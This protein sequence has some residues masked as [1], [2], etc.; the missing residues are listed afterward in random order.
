MSK[1]QKRRN[2][3]RSLLHE[4]LDP[5]L[6]MTVESLIQ[7]QVQ[8]E[9]V[10]Q[11]SSQAL[12]TLQAAQQIAGLTPG[13]VVSPL[14]VTTNSTTP[15]FTQPT[16]N[17]T[18]PTTVNTTAPQT[19]GYSSTSTSSYD[20]S[21]TTSNP[22]GSGS[23][24]EGSPSYSLL[25]SNSNASAV[26]YGTSSYST[27]YGSDYG[28]S[29]GSD[30]G[31]SSSGG[32]SSSNSYPSSTQDYYAQSNSQYDYWSG[33]SG[34][35]SYG[36]T[37]GNYGDNTGSTNPYGSGYGEPDYSGT[38][39]YGNGG[40]DNGNN[41][42]PDDQNST[43]SSASTNEQS[44]DWLSFDEYGR[45][46][47]TTSN[48][49]ELGPDT[50]WSAS[51][52]SAFSSLSNYDTTTQSEV[53][54][55]EST[56]LI[57]DHRTR[58]YE[59]LGNGNYRYIESGS[60]T[61]DDDS[62]EGETN[63]VSFT[64][65]I[66]KFGDLTT[67]AILASS[68]LESPP[69]DPREDY[70]E[71]M[72]FQYVL[73]F[74]GQ[75]SRIDNLI[76]GTYSWN[77]SFDS[78]EVL[79]EEDTDELTAQG[80]A[81]YVFETSVSLLFTA[82]VVS[83]T[84]STLS[85]A[86]YNRVGTY[87]V[88]L[89]EPVDDYQAG[90]SNSSNYNGDDQPDTPITGTLSG[91][92]SES[93]FS[94]I[95][96]NDSFS[97]TIDVGLTAANLETTIT[98]NFTF[99]SSG[100]GTYG[101][102][103]I[104]GTIDE[105]LQES[106]SVNI[107][108]N[109][110]FADGAWDVSGEFES[111]YDTISSYSDSWSGTYEYELELGTMAGEISGSTS[112]NYAYSIHQI[113]I[114]MWEVAEENGPEFEAI[115]APPA[116]GESPAQEDEE[117]QY[118]WLISSLSLSESSSY[119]DTSEYSGTASL[120]S[121]TMLGISTESGTFLTSNNYQLELSIDGDI[122]VG[123]GNHD[124]VYSNE[125]QFNQTL[126]G[127]KT[128]NQ[129]VGTQ[130]DNFSITGK[131]YFASS[132]I[133]VIEDQPADA[134]SS[135]DAEGSGWRSLGGNFDNRFLYQSD[136]GYSVSGTVVSGELSGPG[137]EKEQSILYVRS[138]FIGS[139]D[140]DENL[141]IEDATDIESSVT[142]FETSTDLQGSFSEQAPV[143]DV[144]ITGTETQAK[145]TSEITRF[146]R[147]TDSS[148][149]SQPPI[150]DGYYI[151]SLLE[152]S[153]SKKEAGGIYQ[154]E[155]DDTNYSGTFSYLLEGESEST[156]SINYVYDAETGWT[157]GFTDLSKVPAGIN[158]AMIDV[159]SMDT[160]DAPHAAMNKVTFEHGFHFAFL[161]SGVIE[162]DEDD[163]MQLT[164][165]A[166]ESGS[167]QAVVSGS[168]LS[169]AN[170]TTTGDDDPLPEEGDA[171][172]LAPDSATPDQPAANS[173]SEDED[174]FPELVWTTTGEMTDS[175]AAVFRF[176][177]DASGTFTSGE[178]NGSIASEMEAD[179]SSGSLERFDWDQTTDDWDQVFGNRFELSDIDSGFRSSGEGSID[180]GNLSGSITFGSYGRLESN[181]QRIDNYVVGTEEWVS[182]GTRS[183]KNISRSA[184][185]VTLSGLEEMSSGP[186]T[187]D[188]EVTISVKS[189]SRTASFKE[190][191][192][193][194]DPNAS[195]SSSSAV[196][197]YRWSQ[198]DGA[199]TTADD[200][201]TF[202]TAVGSGPYS[203]ETANSLVSGDGY[204]NQRVES[205]NTNYT[206]RIF[207]VAANDWA[208]TRKTITDYDV[209][210]DQ[211]YDGVGGYSY[212]VGGGNVT[213]T[214]TESDSTHIDIHYRDVTSHRKFPSESQEID[215][216]PIEIPPH[217]VDVVAASEDFLQSVPGL[218]SSF[219][220]ARALTPNDGEMSLAIE[221]SNSLEI[222]GTGSFVGDFGGEGS[223]TIGEHSLTG[224]EASFSF[225]TSKDSSG[226]W[227]ELEGSQTIAT[228]SIVEN[229]QSFSGDWQRQDAIY[230]LDGSL[231][232]TTSNKN[233]NTT[234]VHRDLI[235]GQ[236]QGSRTVFYEIEESRQDFFEGDGPYQHET[237][238]MDISGIATNGK[239]VLWTNNQTLTRQY[240]DSGALMYAIGSGVSRWS[241]SED[242][243]RNGG[244]LY[245]ANSGDSNTPNFSHASVS[246]SE[247]ET[248]S[249]QNI[250]QTT[251][252]LADGNL[253]PAYKEYWTIGN[254]RYFSDATAEASSS[255]NIST[256]TSSYSES[257]TSS[258]SHVIESTRVQNDY[259]LTP[260]ASGFSAIVI[261]GGNT[262][263]S[264]TRSSS[265]QRSVDSHGFE[266]NSG[267][268]WDAVYIKERFHFTSSDT[269]QSGENVQADGTRV[270]FASGH[271]NADGENSWERFVN[272][273]KKNGVEVDLPEFRP[274]FYNYDT[275]AQKASNS[276]AN[277][278]YTPS[279][280]RASVGD[281]KGLVPIES[282]EHM[283]ETVLPAGESD[284]NASPITYIWSQNYLNQQQ[285]ELFDEALSQFAN[286]LDSA[287]DDEATGSLQELLKRTPYKPSEG[288][289]QLQPIGPY[290]PGD[291]HM[292]YLAEK[293][294]ASVENYIP[295]VHSGATTYI[296]ETTGAKIWLLPTANGWKILVEEG[297][298]EEE[299]QRLLDREDVQRK[300]NTVAPPY[301]M[302]DQM[303][304]ID[305][306]FYGGDFT[307]GQA[308]QYGG[309]V[310]GFYKGYFING[311]KA[312]LV[313]FLEMS[314]NP[315]E[316]MELVYQLA[317]MVGAEGPLP[318]FQAIW[319]DV[320][321]SASGD[322][323]K[324]GE[325]FFEVVTA[326]LG[327]AATPSY[328]QKF[329]R[330]K[331]I[332]DK[333]GK[334]HPLV[335]SI[336][337]MG[338]KAAEVVSKLRKMCFARDTLVS[339]EHGLR[340]IGEVLSGEKVYA[341]DFSTGE[342]TLRAVV[343]RI[344]S[345]YSGPMVHIDL[346]PE[347][348]A[349][350]MNHPLW[351]V[352]GIG[353]R[354][355]RT[356]AGF[357]D[358]QDQGGLLSGRWVNSQDLMVGDLLF[359]QDGQLVPIERISQSLVSGF[360]VSNLEVAD[361]HT[362]A[363]GS[364]RV[365]AHNEAICPTG[366]AFLRDL[367]VSGENSYE[368]IK[369]FV[370]SFNFT[371]GDEVLDKLK[372][373]VPKGERV[374]QH[375]DEA[376]DVNYIGITDDLK[377]RAGQHRLDKAKS[378]QSMKPMTDVL[379]HDQASTIEAMKIRQRLAEARAKGLIDGTEPVAEQLRKAGL[380]N[381]NR[382]RDP[383]RWIDID[384][385]D[386][387]KDFDD[388]FDIR[389]PNG[390]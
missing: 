165:T 386:F 358:G 86:Y 345:M 18:S 151:V 172:T 244:A 269:A 322:S 82:N 22:Y 119:L 335:K 272:G 378:G 8:N 178:I 195:T 199:E 259:R 354:D 212:E 109:V 131:S 52:A 233:T 56:L 161:G 376:G 341:F 181:S 47:I 380:L 17:S 258:S 249:N 145:L 240:D 290:I 303:A 237:G 132:S 264:D 160:V 250:E 373:L 100:Q 72:A 389:T 149:L 93:G 308:Q 282:I 14:S 121:G 166:S 381:N 53:D 50:V 188:A 163:S 104:T 136:A 134:P 324:Q 60:R 304:D 289:L 268:G 310:V 103:R 38:D 176:T 363:V 65:L 227:G 385:D 39:P 54:Q 180:Q 309:N 248:S 262:N 1:Q 71:S 66:E 364:S 27:G 344:D 2:H 135:E 67:L 141:T 286:E 12:A 302:A 285:M 219:D 157:L 328:L 296:D 319:D 148:D 320:K 164:G 44:P 45:A 191:E 138:N 74:D 150:E 112:S 245:Q 318:L 351:V 313:G 36:S 342:W 173:N 187:F 261:S 20:S 55:E 271:G 388:I 223:G 75:G 257:A 102:N 343:S 292:Q 279:I 372:A 13:S 265:S 277:E 353:L 370:E 202:Y 99:N 147:I 355:R 291:L 185:N 349:V 16:L 76:S 254:Y 352:E 368:E 40:G 96:L 81:S 87:T 266:S 252:V 375:L 306:Y 10:S 26:D 97:Y 251:Y 153:E 196:D 315:I 197:R 15:I 83:G 133:Y 235:D 200:A 155:Q 183:E 184:S 379:T 177:R 108:T 70:S 130:W 222:A 32:S 43:D 142:L 78:G 167:I 156:T 205:Q 63:S 144:E 25:T 357:R 274:K 356:P 317:M 299:L 339:T 359:N 231:S 179:F 117:G 175:N 69:D 331:A 51:W 35:S 361:L 329:K 11:L 203:R 226:K 256:A 7:D 246:Y 80:F 242:W 216:S 49:I 116:D 154:R 33:S 21:S 284:P 125:T 232:W 383:S 348:I 77:Y 158:T 95:V 229:Q 64:V 323:E 98:E 105:S 221:I 124:V 287:L 6:V 334:D 110:S 29:Y 294:G 263:H 377:R 9:T 387:I 146:Y 367:L 288:Q 307:R 206:N 247:V 192:L 207:L 390:G 239:E 34:G 312:M 170:E 107:T 224:M 325:L 193:Q 234:T 84:S 220:L 143:I 139:S 152:S 68:S 137:S 275:P 120:T 337:A 384:P 204:L 273:D 366:E 140:A 326:L 62:I 48:G 174:E 230:R 118:V 297:T 171:L 371:N 127:V 340:P 301:Q 42:N 122:V 270:P 350:T 327:G 24:Y 236:W 208:E 293:P 3:F 57:I 214:V 126:E 210:I 23:N 58:T 92:F 305:R 168:L 89:D 382:G 41:T 374:Y 276:A 338:E 332:I 333:L 194:L 46:I 123:S 278:P 209:T 267:G 37:S 280:G 213:G 365:L 260:M 30:Y 198:V 31:N 316:T 162:S 218:D 190:E 321:E 281:P 94:Q 182:D 90:Q 238:G 111:D 61:I 113:A 79:I 295:G 5:R 228:S 189:N 369:A 330:L 169:L 73:S 106:S 19:S 300:L 114:L 298:S 211:G 128:V 346:G 28:S 243:T 311:P 85:R 336:D 314:L 88:S 215:L 360:P 283:G 225:S 347:S 59:S 101:N 115:M 217:L 159:T 4:T 186:A 201:Y 91:T 129:L 253:I 255:I 362:Y 241:M